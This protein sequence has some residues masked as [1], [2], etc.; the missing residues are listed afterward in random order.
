MCWFVLRLKKYESIRTK[1][2]FL[3]RVKM[4]LHVGIK[5]FII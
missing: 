3:K 1:S 2:P 5:R 4:I